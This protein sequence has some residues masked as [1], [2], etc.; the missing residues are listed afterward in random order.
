MITD[1]LDEIILAANTENCAAFF[2]TMS[3]SQR[4]AL[5][6][7]ALQWA[8][9]IYGYLCR[10]RQQL[11]AF[12]QSIGQRHRVLSKHPIGQSSFPEAV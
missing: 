4:K 1:Q 11:M 12:D 6:A 8:S 5:S 10:N 9:A 2:E 3:E 7:R